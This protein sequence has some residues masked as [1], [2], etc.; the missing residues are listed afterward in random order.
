MTNWKL[1]FCSLCLISVMSASFGLEV[2]MSQANMEVA[3]GDDVTL[4]CNFK[5][6]NQNNELIV[7]TWTGDADETSGE[8][9]I[10]GSY[11]SYGKVDIGPDYQGKALIE[12]DLTAKT[13]KLTL[14]EVT[15]KESRR[16]RCFVQIPGDIEG[17][18]ADTT[19]LL[20]QV[21]PSQPICK[22]VGTA[23]YGHN[24]SLTCVSEEG[25]PTP[26]YKWERYNV[27]N[28]PQAFPLK[29]TEKDGVLSLVNVSMETSGYYICLSSNKVGSA[30]CNMTLT[31]IPSSMNL[32]TIGIVA[33]CVAGVTVLIIVIICCC[34]KRKQ[35]A[36]DYEMEN[37]V[38]EYHDKPPLGNTEDGNTD[39]M[40][41][42]EEG[43]DKA[44][45]DDLK[46][47]CDDRRGSRDDLK[48]RY[49]D[50]RGSRDDLKDR[51]DDRR[52]SRDDL[53]DR[54]DDRRGSRDDLRDRYDDRRGSRD[55]LKDRYDDRR[56]RGSRDDLRDRYDDR[57]GSRDD[58]RD[59]YD[60]RRGSRDDLRDRYD[61]RKGSRDDLRDRYNDQRDSYR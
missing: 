9:V 28:V 31:V 59:R 38:V 20:V 51:Y 14:K 42:T 24:I 30:K 29:T 15:L 52:G 16:I 41:I 50:R 47:H 22:V 5:P 44:C 36:K 11:Y 8:K 7:I 19:F 48:D 35:K 61:E 39:I 37:P 27:K 21:A 58:L 55:D 34:R 23:E 1:I 57:R 53:R 45:I 26:T 49:D 33:G 10:F 13:T 12:T 2:T 40:A 25:S 54:Y 43:T 6:K 56:G 32:A 46:N 60:E 18:T 17:K 3:R 4:T